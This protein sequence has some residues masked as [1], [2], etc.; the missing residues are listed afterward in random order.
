ME[1][2]A[3]DGRAS[4]RA[5]AGVITLITG[6][7]KSGK[8][9]RALALASA[10]PPPALFLA[11]AE[12]LDAD[13]RSRIARHRA[14]RAGMGFVTLEEPLDLAA[15]LAPRRE[16]YVLADCLTM[17]V[18]NVLR[19]GREADFAAMLGAFIAELWTRDGAVVVSNET[20]LGNI[21]MDA[22]SRRYNLMLAE[23][24]RAVAAAASRVELMVAGLPLVVK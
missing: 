10:W 18:S 12:A 13:M 4:A 11:T 14:E 1:H 16:R 15:A 2:A 22:L 20:G 8:S 5:G 24:N 19:D 21:P 9:T 6:G 3:G 7:V 23:A 17:W